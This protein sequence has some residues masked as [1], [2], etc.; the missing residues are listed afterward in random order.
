N[1][2][3]GEIAQ[4]ERIAAL[5]VAGSEPT[6]EIHPPHPV[7]LIFPRQR[8][9]MRSTTTEQLSPP[10]QSVSINDLGD[11]AARRPGLVATLVLQPPLQFLR[12]PGRMRRSQCN[13]R[14]FA[15]FIHGIAMV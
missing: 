13:D 2:A 11:R 4:A 9:K 3:A 8:R 6:F 14:C 5:P 7:R 1:I 12:T 10:H 15:S